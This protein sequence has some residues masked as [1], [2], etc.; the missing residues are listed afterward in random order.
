[1]KTKTQN[2]QTQKEVYNE[3]FYRLLDVLNKKIIILESFNKGLKIENK[4]LKKQIQNNRP[5]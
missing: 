2:T 1:M 4:K 5:F 3:N